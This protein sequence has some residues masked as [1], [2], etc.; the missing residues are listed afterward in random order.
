MPITYRA[1]RSETSECNEISENMSA[2]GL[3]VRALAAEAVLQVSQQGQSLTDVLPPAQARLLRERDGA[4]LQEMV[5]GVLRWYMRLQCL[6]EL[7]LSK[8]L[9]ERDQDLFHLILVGLYQLEYMHVPGHAAVK[10]TV[11]A[12]HALGKS[13]SRGLI[14]A[15][16]RRYQRE[17]ESLQARLDDNP[18]ARFA[19]PQWLIGMLQQDWPQDWSEILDANNQRPPMTLRVNLQRDS[20]ESYSRLLDEAGREH[21]LPAHAAGAVMLAQPVAVEQLPG[22]AA[23]RVSVQDLAAQLTAPL[24]QAKSGMRVLDACAAPGGKTTQILETVPDLA[25]LVALDIDGGRLSRVQENIERL[26]LR[27]NLVQ[28]DAATP[29]NW[30]DH[31][32]FDRILLDVP[33]SATG[34]IRRHPDIKLLR[35]KSDVERLVRNQQQIL[36]A[37][38]PLLAAGGMLLYSTCSILRAENENQILAFLQRHKDAREVVIEAAWG[39]AC[40]AGRQILPGTENMDG[41]YFS[42]IEKT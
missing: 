19:H 9:K 17:R 16:L 20:R 30:W 8:P 4:L 37:I 18:V 2:Q 39:Q 21:T 33:C 42:R 28:G 41:F 1:S 25:E 13:W 34:V 26:G 6:A 38:W 40:V 15:L 11:D 36:E 10:E 35:R 12:A 32:P 3:P 27:A 31:Q 24:L 23:G 14:N 5:Y 7:M 22:F 29:E